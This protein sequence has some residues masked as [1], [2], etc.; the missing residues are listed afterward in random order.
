MYNWSEAATYGNS[1]ICANVSTTYNNRFVGA[2]NSLRDLLQSLAWIA[3][4]V[5]CIP[6]VTHDDC[7]SEWKREGL[8]TK[9][10]GKVASSNVQWAVYRWEKGMFIYPMS[11]CCTSSSLEASA[12]LRW[13]YRSITY[14]KFEK[15]THDACKWHRWRRKLQL[16]VK[17]GLCKAVCTGGKDN[18]GM[19]RNIAWFLGSNDIK[20]TIGLGASYTCLMLRTGYTA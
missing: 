5:G 13:F 18:R 16:S 9:T 10:Q 15:A 7:L 3:C 2:H 19:I 4:K 20:R 14:P 11:Y 1:S 8:S 6:L 12:Y 17:S